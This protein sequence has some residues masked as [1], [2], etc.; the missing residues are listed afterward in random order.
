MLQIK[1][2]CLFTQKY[3]YVCTL[4]GFLYPYH[5]Y[6]PLFRWL[7]MLGYSWHIQLILYTRTSFT[8]FYIFSLSMLQLQLRRCRSSEFGCFIDFGRRTKGRTINSNSSVD[9]ASVWQLEFAIKTFAVEE[10]HPFSSNQV[11]YNF[12]SLVN[13][14]FQCI[15]PV[16]KRNESII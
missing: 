2:K 3:L 13:V 11:S 4:K 7:W 15:S 6:L 16:H 10:Y 12:W 8:T 1:T 5:P 14:Y 9:V